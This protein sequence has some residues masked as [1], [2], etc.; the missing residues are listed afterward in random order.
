MLDNEEAEVIVN[1]PE[2]IRV[3]AL[4]GV[5]IVRLPGGGAQIVGWIDLHGVE[6]TVTERRIVLRCAVPPEAIIAAREQV[7]TQW[8]HQEVVQPRLRE[9]PSRSAK[10]PWRC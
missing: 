5:R 1:E 4:S 9:E 6:G 2:I 8:G 10:K 3:E 7:R